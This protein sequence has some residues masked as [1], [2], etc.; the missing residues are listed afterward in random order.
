[1][2]N[3][4]GLS[5]DY[6]DAAAALLIDGQLVAAI[7]EERLSRVKHDPSLPA[8]AIQACLKHAGI[9]PQ[10]L[11]AVV[12]YENPL[13]KFDRIL[14]TSQ[15]SNRAY[16]EE[17]LQAWITEGKFSPRQR[18]ANLLAIS[19]EKI[20]YGE[21]HR[22][23][24]A[25]AYY[26]SPFQEAAIVTVDGVG[27]YETATI[28][29][30][31]GTSLHKLHHADFPSSLGL[32]YSAMTAY[33]GFEVNEGEYKVM[34]M[35]SY[36]TPRHTDALRQ[37]YRNAAL[38]LPELDPGYF[39]L[40]ASSEYPFTEALTRLLGP[41]RIAETPFDP[42]RDPQSQRHADIAASVQAL[43]EEIYLDLCRQALQETGAPT[44]CIAGGVA[45]NSK[46]NRRLQDELSVPLFIQPAAGDAGGAL[47]AA[48]DWHYASK[49]GQARKTPFDVYQGREF[50]NE[51]ICRILD[52][53]GIE[54]YRRLD[55]ADLFAELAQQ[56][57]QGKVIGWL[58]G[59]SE[60]G[61][62]SLG[63]RSILADPRR[64]EMKEVVNSR[65]K[66][67]ELFRPFAPSVLAEKAHEYFDLEADIP[68]LAPEDF[69]LSVAKATKTALER[70]PAVIHVDGTSRLQLV[71]A[72]T[73]PR[74][75]ALISA[76][77]RL[78]GVPVLLNTSFNRRG[79]PIVDSPQDAL[80]TFMWTDI[81]ILVMEN[82]VIDK[83]TA[84]L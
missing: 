32:F 5:F 60:W 63:S 19:P 80:N 50:G 57:S 45:L 9:S 6:H 34:G 74:Y 2:A 14:K 54:G 65:I 21:H 30:G 56:I 82:I 39:D 41:Q 70:I 67:R 27:E 47:G 1:M 23:H 75:H 35:A 64:Q 31:Q 77:E 20:H 7:Q 26:P 40:L 22:S 46:A 72:E 62:R 53:A 37:V 36:G 13:R 83:A 52:E 15:N 49:A 58:N 66:F 69:M 18:I 33:L 8:K 38:G 59:R 68:A 71:R 17:T 55:D 29:K 16:L 43:T 48:L 76:F 25:S 44:L 51:E 78:T 61:P 4:L 81:D 84:C 28:W 73:N 3:I 12:F 11:D 79:E 42:T 24:A 10:A